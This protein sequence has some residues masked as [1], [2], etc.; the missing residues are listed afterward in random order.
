[1]IV[2]VYEF[3]LR[4][5]GIALASLVGPILVGM[6]IRFKWPETAKKIVKVKL[7]N[8]SDFV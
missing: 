2:F 4:F 1:M 7:I 5:S 3:T 8:S 6:A